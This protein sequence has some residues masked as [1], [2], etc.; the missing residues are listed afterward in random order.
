[1]GDPS[2]QMYLRCAVHAYPEFWYDTT[3]HTSIGCTPFKV[4]YGYDAHAL[5]IPN[6]VELKEQ[7]ARAPLRMKPF[8]PRYTTQD[9]LGDN[10][11]FEAH[12]SIMIKWRYI[13]RPMHSEAH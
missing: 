5:A 4:L 2:L 9:Y 8:H 1:M 6:S 11:S 13:D 12:Y 7:L 10:W 3:Y